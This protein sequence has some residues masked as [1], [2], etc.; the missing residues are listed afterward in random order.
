MTT[1]PPPGLVAPRTP[2]R[3][4]GLGGCA[5]W[6]RWRRLARRRPA[7]G[8][9]R[10]DGQMRPAGTPAARPW[11]PLR[12]LP[13]SHDR[14]GRAEQP[15][16]P[17]RQRGAGRSSRRPRGRSQPWWGAPSLASSP[18]RFHRPGSTLRSPAVPSQAHGAGSGRR[19]NGSDLSPAAARPIQGRALGQGGRGRRPAEVARYRRPRGQDL[20]R[21]VGA[22]VDVGVDAPGSRSPPTVDRRRSGGR[23]RPPGRPLDQAAAATTVWPASRSRSRTIEHSDPR[24][25][26]GRRG[27]GGGESASGS[28]AVAILAM[29][30][31]PASLVLRGRQQERPAAAGPPG[32]PVR[33]QHHPIDAAHIGMPS[34][35]SPRH[36]GPV[37]A[38]PRPPSTTADVTESIDSDILRSGPGHR[39]Y[40]ELGRRGRRPTW[41]TSTPWTSPP[42]SFPKATQDPVH[43]S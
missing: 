2:A 19:F 16:G 34:P 37:P 12:T 20:R 29:N 22:G 3:R 33:L 25:R 32:H 35:T 41:R 11:P 15:L 23:P 10:V 13:T 38:R 30:S 39:D 42:S 5:G 27:G 4:A 7:P 8:P 40:L 9:G 43:R 1:S 31:G 18:S 36:P 28:Y 26:P 6:A 17:G 21:W 24:R 14:A